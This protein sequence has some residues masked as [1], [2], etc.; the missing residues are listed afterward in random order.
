MISSF[1]TVV[2]TSYGQL[3][4]ES[5]SETA[6]TSYTDAIIKAP[7]LIAQA[8]IVGI[9]FVHSSIFI[10]IIKKDSIFF[11]NNDENFIWPFLANNKQFIIIISACGAIIFNMSTILFVYQASLLSSDLGLDLSSTLSLL[12]SSSVG[13][14]YIIKIVTS[15]I[16]IIL[17]ILYYYIAKTKGRWKYKEKQNIKHQ[18]IKTIK[19]SLTFCILIL[20]LDSINIFSN[21]IQSHSAAVSFFPYIAISVDLLHF[22]MVS[23]WVGGL[24]YIS[25]I[26]RKLLIKVPNPQQYSISFI[27]STNMHLF[28]SII[29]RFSIIAIISIG[30]IFITGLYMGL[31]HLQQPSSLLNSSYGNTLIVKLLIVFPMALLGGYHQFRLHKLINQKIWIQ[32]NQQLQKLK[33]FHKSLKIEFILGIGVIFTSSFLTIT[34]P[35]QHDE[36]H[37]MDM[38]IWLPSEQSDL[39]KKITNSQNYLFDQSFSFIV[40]VLS[41]SIAISVIFFTRR[42]WLNLKIYN[43]NY[44]I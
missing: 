32:V 41:I 16:I 42:S 13:N 17:S 39:T 3:T 34:S 43:Q 27:N 12:L 6:I 8:L 35:P 23:I 40:L 29:L 14:I 22:M 4:I 25:L 37:N 2:Q 7:L 44:H 9:T 36:F 10:P 15:T 18:K 30:T 38:K 33:I 21:S 26:S 24:F 5:K 20:I 28:L 11:N 19:V 31:L 1:N